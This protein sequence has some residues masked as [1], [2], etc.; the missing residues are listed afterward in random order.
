M[1]SKYYDIDE[2]QPLKI[3]TKEKS[4]SFFHINSCLPNKNFEELQ[5]LLMS[6]NTQFDVIAIAETRIMKNNSIKHLNILISI[7]LHLKINWI[8]SGV[9][10]S[11]YLI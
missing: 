11:L 6:A 5:N 9:Q 4:L 7:N 1:Q 8:T 2:L 10:K 3:L